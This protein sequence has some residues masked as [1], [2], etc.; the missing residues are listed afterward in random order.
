MIEVGFVTG[1]ITC[2]CSCITVGIAEVCSLNSNQSAACSC[3]IDN[4]SMINFI[5]WD[6]KPHI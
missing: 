2:T 4:Y 3:E 5:W 6:G 1:H